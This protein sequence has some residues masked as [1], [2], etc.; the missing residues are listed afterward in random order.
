M[1]SSLRGTAETNPTSVHEDTGSIPDLAQSAKDSIAMSCGVGRRHSSDPAW[2]WVWYRP[3]AVAPIGPLA[4]ELPYAKGTALKK[5]QKKQKTNKQ[6]TKKN[7]EGESQR[8][9]SS[10]QEPLSL[11]VAK[12]KKLKIKSKLGQSEFL[13][14]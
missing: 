12:Q 2:L 14:T 13:S 10:S 4:W 9:F 8:V 6:T 5:K 7:T 3:A 11:A 1:R